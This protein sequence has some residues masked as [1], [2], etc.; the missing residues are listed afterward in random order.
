MASETDFRQSEA[1]VESQLTLI[2]RYHLM[3]RH[4]RRIAQVTLL[5]AVLVFSTLLV[6]GSFDSSVW[7]DAH[8]GGSVTVTFHEGSWWNYKGHTRSVTVYVNG[9][10]D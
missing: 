6:V 2:R 3:L 10:H 4:V 1:W 5:T 8:H 7:S 9:G